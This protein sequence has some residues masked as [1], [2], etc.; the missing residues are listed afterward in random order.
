MHVPTVNPDWTRLGRGGG[1]AL[2]NI[3]WV[4]PKRACTNHGERMCGGVCVSER[5]REEQGGMK[6]EEGGSGDERS[7]A[8]ARGGRGEARECEVSGQQPRRGKGS[9]WER[10]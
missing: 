4:A 3:G 5:E 9:G 6:G 1:F 10:R 2:L 7:A 8:E